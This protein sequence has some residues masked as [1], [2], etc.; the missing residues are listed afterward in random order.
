MY[1]K[2][3]RVEVLPVVDLLK[4]IGEITPF[5]LWAVQHRCNDSGRLKVNELR[6]YFRVA[7]N[8]NNPLYCAP[9]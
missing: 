4:K 1:K 7:D 6:V 8:G 5:F 9:V 2:N 3:T